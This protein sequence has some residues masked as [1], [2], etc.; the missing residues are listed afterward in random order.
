MKLPQISEE[1]K[2]KL[3]VYL[4]VFALVF[5]A[6]SYGIV[7]GI[8]NLPPA[9][10]VWKLYETARDLQRYW[11]NDFGLEANRHLVPMREGHEARFR[12]FGDGAYEGRLLMVSGLTPEREALNSVLLLD[13]KG[14]EVHAWPVDYSQIDPEGP[15]PENV[16]LHGLDVFEDGSIAVNFDSGRVLARLDSCGKVMWKTEGNFHHAVTR[17]FDGTLW[18]LRDDKLVQA[19]A[20]SGKVLKEA[21]MMVDVLKQHNLQGVLAIQSEEG[22]TG[23]RMSPDPFHLNHIEALNPE[24]AAAFPMFEAGDL[25]ISMRSLNM[26]AVLDPGVFNIKWFSIGP[27]H[28]QHE[29][30]FLQDGTIAVYNNNM[31]FEHSQIMAI[32]PATMKTRIVFEGSED[33]PFYSWRRGKHQLFGNGDVLIVEAEHGRAFMV[34]KDGALLWEYNNRY[35]ETRNGVLNKAVLLPESFFDVGA[36]R[37]CVSAP[38]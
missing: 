11:K 36:L 23:L 30:R 12:V 21:G 34:N 19:D 26:I 16:F 4:F 25:L 2:D 18:S 31:G 14:E 27:W 17:S 6:F 15:G 10:Q 32:D 9:Y 20:E 13:A 29:P 3:P 1:T 37:K 22:P 8:W 35:D 28:R 38:E 24:M 7:A 5:S 33:V